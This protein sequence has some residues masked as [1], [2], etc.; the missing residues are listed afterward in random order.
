GLA[1]AHRIRERVPAAVHVARARPGTP[2]QGPACGV[3]PP[4]RRRQASCAI[5]MSLGREAGAASRWAGEANSRPN[6]G[7][8][9]SSSQIFG[10]NWRPRYL[11]SSDPKICDELRSEEHTSELQSL[12]YL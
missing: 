12:A 3:T 6:I 2:A 9:S 10:S 5:E 11:A 8:A 7:L 4:R 1:P